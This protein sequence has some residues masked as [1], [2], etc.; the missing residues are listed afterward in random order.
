MAIQSKAN[1]LELRLYIGVLAYVFTFFGSI[2][3]AQD[4]WH[5]PIIYII[6]AIFL[7]QCSRFIKPTPIDDRDLSEKYKITQDQLSIYVKSKRNF[8]IFAAGMAAFIGLFLSLFNFKFSFCFVIY[9]IMIWCFY[10]L[11]RIFI[12]KIPAPKTQNDDISRN[13]HSDSRNSLTWDGIESNR[14][15]NM[16]NSMNTSSF[17]SRSFH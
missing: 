3:W 11:Y 4:V 16:W 8:R 10:P 6:S 1:I 13:I 12:L 14:V 2:A 9:C 17:H 15:R 5:I 7:D